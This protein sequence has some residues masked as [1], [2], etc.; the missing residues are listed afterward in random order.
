[1][2]IDKIQILLGKSYELAKHAVS[3]NQKLESLE[4]SILKRAFAG[5][6]IKTKMDNYLKEIEA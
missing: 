4:Q 2:I 3:V 5:D 1:V 6:L